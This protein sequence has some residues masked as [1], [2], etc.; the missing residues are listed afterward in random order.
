MSLLCY[1][2]WMVS[3]KTCKQNNTIVVLFCLFVYIC[4]T[5][6]HK[7]KH[8]WPDIACREREV[9]ELDW[10]WV[11]C[12]QWCENEFDDLHCTHHRSDR[13]NYMQILHLYHCSSNT[14]CLETPRIWTTFQI[15]L[16]LTLYSG[17]ILSTVNCVVL[18]WSRSSVDELQCKFE[19]SCI[20][21]RC[22][23]VLDYNL[24]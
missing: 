20:T 3:I 19:S 21:H 10:I 12:M 7:H 13:N 2:I 24:S 22:Y 5:H 9:L 18:S 1:Q 15:C 23:M 14:F 16:R 8:Y 6:T 17:L 11:K 4:H